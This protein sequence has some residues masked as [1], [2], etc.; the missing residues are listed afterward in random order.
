MKAYERLLKYVQYPT[1]SDENSETCPS[2]RE[3]LV[4]GAALCDEMKELGISGVEM[5]ENGYVYGEIP[6]SE[7]CENAPVLGFISHMDVVEEVPFTNIKPRIVD[8][9]G[10]DVVLNDELGIVLSSKDFPEMADCIGK[11]IIVTDGTTLLGAD[12]KNGIAEILT[13]AEELIAHPE[14]KHGTIKIGF[15]PDEEIGRGAHKFN[16]ARFGADYAYTMDGD[17][18]GGV[19]YETFNAAHAKIKFNGVSVHPGSAKDKMINAALVAMDFDALLPRMERPEYT[20]EYQG[21]YYLTGMHGSCDNAELSYIIRDHDE[22]KL[23]YRVDYIHRAAAEIN[24][25]Y[26]EGIAEAETGFDYK[27]MRCI[28]ENHF[29]LIE[30]ARKAIEKAG[31]V[32]VSKPVRGGTDGCVLSFMGLL[33]PNLGTGGYNFHGKFE[34]ACIEQMDSA[35]EMIKNLAEIYGT[36]KK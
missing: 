35:V 8:Y 23:K 30:N 29:H 20:E 4:L 1:G 21:F 5:D 26:G 14:I 3:Q 31:G 11:H 10:G 28:I 36:L 33:C 17:A 6:A 27:N 7:G 2:T 15:T 25:R 12:D 13:A 19:E 18:F 9:N 34:F 32:P 22:E 16:L 24:R